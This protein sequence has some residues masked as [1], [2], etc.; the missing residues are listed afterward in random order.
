MHAPRRTVEQSEADLA[1]NPRDHHADGRLRDTQAG[2]GAAEVELFGY[3]DERS[4][5]A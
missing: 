1:L 2:G 3:C 5:M 4:E